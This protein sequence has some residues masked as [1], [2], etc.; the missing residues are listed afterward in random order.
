MVVDPGW[1]T[2]TV[3][4]RYVVTADRQA[5]RLALDRLP[6]AGRRR[7]ARSGCPKNFN[8]R[9][10]QMRRDLAS[11]LRSRT[12]D[13][14]PPPPGAAPAKGADRPAPTPTARS[15]SCATEL[16]AHPCHACP[17][18]EDHARWARALVQ[19]RPRRR[20][21]A[22]PGRAAHQ[23]RRPPV[24]PGLRGARPRSATWTA[25]GRSAV[26]DQ[27]RHLMRIYSELDLVAAE[28]AAHGP[29]GRPVA[30]RARRRA[31]GAGLRGAAA[32]R[33][34]GAAGARRPGPRGD[35]GDGPALGPSST[36]SS[37]TTSSTS[38]ASP[39]WASPGRP[40]AGPRA[41]SS[42][43]CSTSS[44]WPPATSCAG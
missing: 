29:L 37:A 32:R 20:H 2:P 9:N 5:R 25:T 7:S 8:G 42:T 34:L 17:D 14:A 39:T 10:P 36:R 12:H 31:V 27:G 18:R 16:R 1:S 40:T 30:V 41:T 4:G 44:T 3:R 13:L 43:T 6:G 22:A 35:R 24:R 26:T 21:A 23:H 38:C 11:A 33:R 28:C 19:A 15:P